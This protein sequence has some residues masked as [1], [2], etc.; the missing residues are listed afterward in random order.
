MVDVAKI[1]DSVN[2]ITDIIARVASFG[3]QALPVAQLIAGIIPGGGVVVSAI[4]AA[5]PYIAKVTAAAPIIHKAVAAGVPIADAL[6][7]NGADLLH[8]VKEIYAIAVNA[9]PERPEQRMTGSDVSTKQIAAFMPQVLF[10]G[11]LTQEQENALF[12]R[13]G[14]GSVS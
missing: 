13:F 4:G 8:A 2:T 1:G 14:I 12:D 10:G 7:N 5:L 11:A 9:D 6:Q 3:Q